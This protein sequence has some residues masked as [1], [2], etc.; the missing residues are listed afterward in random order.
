M[1]SWRMVNS[2]LATV[3]LLVLSPFL[4]CHSQRYVSFTVTVP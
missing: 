3:V 4:I 2:L 1:M